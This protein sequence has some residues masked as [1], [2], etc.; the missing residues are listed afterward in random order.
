MSRLWEGMSP[1]VVCLALIVTLHARAQQTFVRTNQLG[2]F[3]GE[4][5][6]ATILSR[7]GL[8]GTPFEILK[9]G[10][11]VYRGT[12]GAS[13]GSYASFSDSYRLNVP[14]PPAEGIYSVRVDGERSYE[15]ARSGSAYRGIVDSLLL[16]FRVQRCGAASALLHQ[17][18]HL[19]DA[20]KIVRGSTAVRA[21]IDL[22]GGWHDAGDYVKFLNTTAYTTY[23]L[24]FAQEFAPSTFGPASRTPG[25][26]PVLDEARVG[27]AWLL[28]A[29]VS[30]TEL[31]TQVQ[32]LRDHDQGWRLPEKDPLAWDRPAFVGTGKNLIGIVSAT[33]ALAAKTF[34]AVDQP[35]ADT[36]LT[37]A[38]DLYSRRNEVPDLDVSGSGMYRDQHFKGKLALAAAELFRTTDNRKYLDQ[39]KAYAESAGADFWWSWG[40]INALADYRLAPI[41]KGFR[42]YLR[43][44]LVAAAENSRRTLFGE[45]TPGSWGSV[46][47]MLGVA[48]QSL[49]WQRLTDD[50][51]FDTLAVRQCNYILGENPWGVSF[52]SNVGQN[53]TRNF[54]S[55]V[56]YL[57]GGYLPGGLA[58]GPVPA[59]TI[60]QYHI[61]YERPDRYAEFQ[62]ESAVY[63]DDRM[64]YITNE[65]TIVAAATAVFVFGC[66]PSTH[67]ERT[68]HD[69]ANR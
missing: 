43:K 23:L 40:D 46:N 5:I 15:F 37:V 50:T 63:H 41:E 68:A 17:A 35:F 57:N 61:A 31:A 9:D 67:Q 1:A 36:C 59:S 11:V 13:L 21:R 30:D 56:A 3:S 14:L 39:A 66:M 52:L 49:L 6:R 22:T 64:D 19:H 34:A 33:M 58:A 10:A 45:A 60:R 53:P 62:T 28:K 54:H 16:F 2:I 47:A 55:Q 69:D 51:E 27:L 24:L 65:P 48:L 38:E 4:P 8:A 42:V 18:C 25:S 20:T 32:D 12:V 26:C 44:N 7:H 29:R